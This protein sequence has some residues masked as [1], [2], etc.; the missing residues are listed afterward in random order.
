MLDGRYVKK[1]KNGHI[2]ATVSL[3][4]TK[5]GTVTHSDHPNRISCH[6]EHRHILA[7]VCPI[8]MKFGKVTFRTISAVNFYTIPHEKCAPCDAALC[9]HS[10]TICYFYN[11]LPT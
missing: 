5:C 11:Y 8:G 2:S 3:I 7:S 6:L 4:A 9:Q 10:L 1:T